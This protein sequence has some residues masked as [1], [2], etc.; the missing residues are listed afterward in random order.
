MRELSRKISY[1]EYCYN[2]TL[3]VTDDVIASRA[4]RNKAIGCALEVSGNDY[5]VGLHSYSSGREAFVII[6]AL[7]KT[8]E[9]TI[10]HECT[11]AVFRLAR[12]IDIVFSPDSEEFFTYNIGHL[13]GEL[14]NLLRDYRK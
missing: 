1:P 9:N 2:I 8:V 5:T 13:V 12:Q 4:K 11:H 6:D 3:I 7:Y 14:H 10:A